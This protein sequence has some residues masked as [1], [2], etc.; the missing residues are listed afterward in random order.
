MEAKS[1]RPQVQVQPRLYYK[2]WA[3]PEELS[4]SVSQNKYNSDVIQDACLRES[5]ALGLISSIKTETTAKNWPITS[6]D[7]PRHTSSRLTEGNCTP[8]FCKLHMQA[9][10]NWEHKAQYRRRETAPGVS[11][12]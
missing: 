6:S 8:L 12:K 1:E 10:F 4:V 2:L 5:R 3:K 7:V 9:L 11:D